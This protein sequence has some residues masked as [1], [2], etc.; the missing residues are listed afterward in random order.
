MLRRIVRRDAQLAQNAQRCSE[1]HD[2]CSSKVS[3]RVEYTCKST[4]VLSEYYFAFN[5]LVTCLLTNRPH[6]P[7]A[8]Q[9]NARARAHNLRTPK[10]KPR[11]TRDSETHDYSE[12]LSPRISPHRLTDTL[13]DPRT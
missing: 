11:D 6:A 13:R 12:R 9:H 10:S 5:R 3:I 1:E 8:V 4:E 7:P 2:R